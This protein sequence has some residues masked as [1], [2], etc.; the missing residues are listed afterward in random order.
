MFSDKY[1]KIFANNYCSS[2]KLQGKDKY[3]SSNSIR[4][5]TLDIKEGISKLKAGIGFDGVHSNHLKL[6]PESFVNLISELLCSFSCHEHVPLNLLKGTIFPTVKNKFGDL[7][8]SD[9]YRPVM[10]SSA[11]YKLFEYC[12]LKHISPYINLNDRQHGFCPNYSTTTACIVLKETIFNY[13]KSNSNVHACFIDIKKAF[14]SVNHEKLMKKLKQC[15]IPPVYVSFIRSMYMNQFAKVRFKGKISEEWQICNGVRQG[16]V[17]SGLFFSI[18]V[19]SLID[20]VS[21]LKYGCR[22]GIQTSNIIVYADDIVLLAPSRKGLQL[23]VDEAVSEAKELDLNFNGDKSKYLLFFKGKSCSSAGQITI[24]EISL[25][26]VRNFKYLGF[27]L[28]ENLNN[29]E[30]IC[31]VRNKFYSDFN[32]LLR[33]FYFADK[34]VKLFLFKQFCLQFYGSE[35]WFTND[36]ALSMLKQFEVGYH[37]AIK[38]ILSLSYHES[39]HYACQEATMFTFKHYLNKIKY[40][41]ALRLFGAP[42]EFIA[43]AKTFLDI[44]SQFLNEMKAIFMNI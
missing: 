28:N 5:S 29:I 38:K 6:C 14:D 11:F 44:S 41:S 33:K 20:K 9:N 35:L 16:G 40:I 43:K 1:K 25:E 12:I 21:S 8:N 32:C 7:R 37:K 23:L 34:R 26:R 19:N 15:G 4:F 24:N 31:R 22:L 13:W 17:L 10:S 36:K 27:I 39:N 18:Y 42:C 3:N 2:H 30:D